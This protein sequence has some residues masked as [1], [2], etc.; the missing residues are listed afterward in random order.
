MG[1]GEERR[2]E[3]EE[4]GVQGVEGGVLGGGSGADAGG[5]RH[6]DG[7]GRVRM[8]AFEGVEEGWECLRRHD[9]EGGSWRRCR[10]GSRV[11]AV[12]LG[13]VRIMV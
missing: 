2:G 5:G 12:M 11:K 13:D 1:G 7:V 9:C 3:G 4:V 6:F 10:L 8:G